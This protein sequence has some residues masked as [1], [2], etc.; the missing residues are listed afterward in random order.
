MPLFQN[1][2]SCEIFHEDK[3]ELQENEPVGRTHCF[4]MSGFARRLVLTPR[5]KVTL[6]MAI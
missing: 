3:F 4:H 2:S 5:H 1:E 6:E